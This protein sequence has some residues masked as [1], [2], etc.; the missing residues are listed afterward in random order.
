MTTTAPAPMASA[1]RSEGATVADVLNWYRAQSPTRTDTGKAEKERL[2]L[3]G[4]FAAAI[5]ERPC[6]ECRPYHL[7]AFINERAGENAWTRKRWGVILSRPF[8]YATRLGLIASNPFRG[9]TFPAGKNGRDWTDGEFRALLRAAA[10]YVRRFIVLIRFSGMRP[11]EIRGLEWKHIDTRAGAIVLDKHKMAYKTK[12]PR[13][14]PFN[15]V[16]VKLLAWLRRNHLP[17]ARNVFLNAYFR[18]WSMRSLG[19]TFL[20]VRHKAG[21]GDDVKL[22]GGR[23]TF[24]TRAIMAGL[25]VATLAEIMGHDDITTTSRYTH[26]AGKIGHLAAAMEQAIQGTP[27]KVAQ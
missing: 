14:I 24:A 12:A 16:I 4:L 21:L 7:L 13:R 11:G 22:H 8:N 5:G 26:L 27:R 15:T 18:P 17:R 6:S 9:L 10:P 3:Y 1:F 19:K 2:R 25:D 23:H 20:T